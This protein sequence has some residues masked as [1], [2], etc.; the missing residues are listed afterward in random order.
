MAVVRIDLSYDGSGFFGFAR[1]PGLRTVQGGLEDALERLLGWRPAT[2]G[3]GR[4]DR[5]V[6]ARHQVVSFEV[7][8]V[9]D[10]DRLT[11][12]LR[13]LLGPE[14]SVSSVAAAADGFNA[15]FSPAWRAY[16]YFIDPSP[17]PNP[18]RRG[19]VWH[20]GV[21]LDLAAMA[22]VAAAFVGRHD[23]AT[24]CRRRE[25]TGTEREVLEANWMVEDALVVFEV[26]ARAFCHQMVR[27][28]VGFSVDV[29]RGRIPPGAVTDVIAARD[30]SRVGTVAPPHGLVLWQ[31][32]FD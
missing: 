7:D 1:Q 24:F 31:V 14:I 13:G 17:T 16:R 3:A 21:R 22:E 27:S 11:R 4:T 26:K 20:L 5:G 9:P 23:F 28:L 30:R 8:E 32:G 29:G 18:L 12:G 2:T 6:H 10:L 15:R 25:G 19:W